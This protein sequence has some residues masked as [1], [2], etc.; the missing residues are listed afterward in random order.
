MG[1]AVMQLTAMAVHLG[2]AHRSC[3]ARMAHPGSRHRQARVAEIR[4][5][6]VPV[7][8]LPYGHILGL[9]VMSKADFHPKTRTSELGAASCTSYAAQTLAVE[10]A[11]A[12]VTRFVV[13]WAALR[14]VNGS[15]DDM[16]LGH[17][18]VEA[19]AAGSE[20]LAPLATTGEALVV[21]C[22][23]DQL[24]C[25]GGVETL[26]RDFWHTA[27]AVGLAS[28]LAVCC[29]TDLVRVTSRT[30]QPICLWLDVRGGVCDVPSHTL[31]QRFAAARRLARSGVSRLVVCC[32]TWLLEKVRNV[33]LQVR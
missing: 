16:A 31:A 12:A 28:D 25:D 20:P 9:V 10:A 6:E 24:R 1:C 29:C 32:H 2:C 15:L 22:R 17:T 30:R 7:G 3:P 26:L 19:L 4:I 21:C 27:K 23:M 11:V 18:V 14:R 8:G 33:A 5:F 13:W